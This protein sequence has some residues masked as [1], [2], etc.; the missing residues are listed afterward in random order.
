MTTEPTTPSV[1]PERATLLLSKGSYAMMLGVQCERKKEDL[2][3]EKEEYRSIVTDLRKNLRHHQEVVEFADSQINSIGYALSRY[4][5]AELRKVVPTDE[6]K[7]LLKN[8]EFKGMWHGDSVSIGAE[9]KRP[10]GNSNM[11]GD[12]ASILGWELPNDDLSDAQK[13]RADVLLEELPFALN[14]ILSSLI[15]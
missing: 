1:T 8:M 11:H 14:S 3:E 2:L 5:D 7:K 10:F 4:R 13:E 15:K 9:G 6:H 12:I